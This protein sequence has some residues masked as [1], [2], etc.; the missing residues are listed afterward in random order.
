MWAPGR[1]PVNNPLMPWY[2]AINQPGAGQMQHGRALMESRPFLTRVPD[3]EV[4]VA[5]RVPTSVPGAGRYQFVATRDSA[6]TYAMVYAPVGRPFKVRMS[7]IAG[8]KVKAW[9]FNPRTGASTA[10]ATFPN[11]G[12]REFTPPDH[13]E[14]LDWILVLD[15]ESKG[16]AAP[17][18]RK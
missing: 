18:R 11:T 5:D 8:A 12:E 9:W 15:D 2:D 7:I 14:Q 10:I 1:N 17:G 13:G 3:Q 6:G 16:Y 4:V